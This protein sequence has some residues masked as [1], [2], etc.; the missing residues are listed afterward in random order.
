MIQTCGAALLGLRI[1]IGRSGRHGV[2]R[3]QS[4]GDFDAGAVRGAQANVDNRAIGTADLSLLQFVSKASTASQGQR[5]RDI[6]PELDR[7]DGN[8]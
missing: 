2:S 8:D 3:L 1:Q 6:E 7:F 5:Q 4:R